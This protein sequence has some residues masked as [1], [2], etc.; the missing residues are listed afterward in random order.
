M[1]RGLRRLG[2]SDALVL[3]LAAAVV[4]L[5]AAGT[6]ALILT[7]ARTGPWPSDDH[8]LRQGLA[9]WPADTRAEAEAE[10]SNLDGRE[11]RL[12]AA[13]TVRRFA[14][15]VLRYPGPVFRLDNRENSHR[16]GGLVNTRGVKGLFLGSRVEVQR[17]GRCWYVVDAAPREGEFFL[18][19]AFQISNGKTRAIA[20]SGGGFPRTEIGWGPWERTIDGEQRDRS[21]IVLHPPA[22]AH[23]E[24]GHYLVTMPDSK[25][26]SE[27]VDV[28]LLGAIPPPADTLLMRHDLADRVGDERFCDS[29]WSSGRG[30]ERIIFDMVEEE[31]G[32]GDRSNVPYPGPS[33]VKE[34]ELGPL[35]WRLEADDADLDLRFSRVIRRC[36]VLDE[37]VPTSGSFLRDVRVGP[38]SFTIDFDWGTANKALVYYGF[39]GE[40]ERTELLRARAPLTFSYAG[41]QNRDLPAG[42]TVVLFQRGRVVSAEHHVFEPP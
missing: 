30:P 7:R 25:G 39:P 40:E 19:L 32:R 27:M 16:T 9:A 21:Q 29:F 38:R 14:S 28:S 36:A 10:C 37:M 8:V 23:G 33:L 34:T 2:S 18:G 26:I 35:H 20:F 24:P 5:G 4:V 12:D 13:A 17:L 42:V 31:F 11:W 6:A 15:E 3:V 1:R 41:T 22:S